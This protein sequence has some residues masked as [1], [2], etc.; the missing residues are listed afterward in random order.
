MYQS[1][2]QGKAGIWRLHPTKWHLV[3]CSVQCTE[4][5][6]E[7]TLNTLHWT[8]Q[9][10]NTHCKPKKSEHCAN[11]TTQT[12]MHLQM[13]RT[14]HYTM[15]PALQC[16]HPLYTLHCHALQL[17]TFCIHTFISALSC[18][19]M[20]ALTHSPL[21]A[22]LRHYQGPG[23][24]TLHFVEVSI[25]MWQATIY[26]APSTHFPT[27]PYF[28]CLLLLK[29]ATS[30]RKFSLRILPSSVCHW[31]QSCFDCWVIW[32]AYDSWKM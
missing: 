16:L 27:T 10:H 19:A 9:L 24:C 15:H 25:Q 29:N 8:L 22:L 11:P 30:D 7:A 23:L 2:E 5:Y 14:S 4:S 13:H 28:T 1:W 17:W 21:P 26:S 32:S 20:I 12:A 3:P 31:C 18:T 6:T